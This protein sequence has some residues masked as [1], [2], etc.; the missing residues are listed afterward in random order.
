MDDQ[1]LINE[2]I[3]L[4]RD[5]AKEKILQANKILLLIEHEGIP[6]VTRQETTTDLLRILHTIKGDSGS[7]GMMEVEGITHKLE[8][9]LKEVN[10]KT[11]LPADL[12]QYSVWFIALDMI[13]ELIEN[14]YDPSVHDPKM[15]EVTEQ[16]A[17]VSAKTSPEKIKKKTKAK[18]SFEKTR[19]KAGK[20]TEKKNAT[21]EPEIKLDQRSKLP[22]DDVIRVTV[23]KLD[24]FTEGM[25]EMLSQRLLHEQQIL[26]IQ[27][28]AKDILD[29]Y[30]KRNIKLQDMIEYLAV[31]YREGF[32]DKEV[33]THLRNL[34]QEQDK[35]S[36][37]I[38]RRCQDLVFQ[39]QK[40]QKEVR[41]L[42]TSMKTQEEDIRGLRMTPV[43]GLFQSF[44]RYVRDTSSQLGKKVIFKTEGESVEL[45]RSIVQQLR[46]PLIHLLRNS[47]DHGIEVPE[48]RLKKGKTET[49]TLTLRAF[50]GG[51]GVII[52]IE[53]DGKGLDIETIKLKALDKG[54][55]TAYDIESM[56]TREIQGVVFSTG[57]STKKEVSKISGR[58]V[59][60]DAVTA[61]AEQLRG[62]V[63]WSS[64]EGEG[65]LVR[66][67][68]PLTMATIKA[69]ITRIRDQKFAV[70]L[71]AVDRVL[72]VRREDLKTVE[73]RVSII[74]EDR[75]V[76]LVTL[77]EILGMP[78]LSD[79]ES[80]EL[81]VIL[82]FGPRGPQA[83]VVDDFLG[84][85]EIVMKN[86]TRFLQ[87]VKNISGAAIWGDGEVI[88]VINS[89]DLHQKTVS[90]Q[91]RLNYMSEHA[92][93]NMVKKRVLVVDDSLITRT[94]ENRILSRAGLDVTEAKDGL[95]AMEILRNNEFDLV[96]TDMQ[97][98]KMDGLE[99]TRSIR[100]NR[101]LS[102]LPVIMVSFQDK[103][104]DK[105][106]G[107]DAG[108]DAYLTKSQFSQNRLL[109]L[110]DQLTGG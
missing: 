36:L 106:A 4:F 32:I 62:R 31:S 60:L 22:Q 70:P 58:G 74:F 49:A 3:P 76:E 20:N 51:G 46:E 75:P 45:D 108:A 8:S 88:L 77:A 37:S 68:L 12:P 33:Y 78:E 24:V 57:F 47:L 81:S 34:H 18:K 7:I 105:L 56:N 98:P 6:D 43:A 59:G 53:D 110:V 100:K 64:E 10:T 16:L 14:E 19:K 107:L 63:E 79:G 67:L 66:L 72:R 54:I 5:S 99:L 69:V 96:V 30:N 92:Q 9:S 55:L 90:G 42:G 35:Y 86:F 41:Q 93:K 26:G 29:G 21:G 38:K 83:W 23:N 102:Q 61:W 80:E 65:M 101:K 94:M 13:T 48:E 50:T 104:E 39:T 109:E 40:S 97:M 17:S 73:G 1:D 89:A 27:A 25:N 15:A 103:E 91:S 84:E 85:R 71:R 52:E 95:D 11:G 44:H 28:Q 2:L 82:S 87:R